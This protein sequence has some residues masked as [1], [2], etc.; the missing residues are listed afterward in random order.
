MIFS[1]FVGKKNSVYFI[2][3]SFRWM[4]LF[5]FSMREKKQTISCYWI[6]K[7]LTPFRCSTLFLGAQLGTRGKIWSDILN[8]Q[9]RKRSYF[10]TFKFPSCV[11]FIHLPRWIWIWGPKIE[12]KSNVIF[13]ISDKKCSI[14]MLYLILKAK[15]FR[16][17]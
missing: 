5:F 11:H 14:S 3:S 6:R 7:I 16:P 4:K 15:S 8:Q 17:F 10:D 13:W 2:S 12:P 1:P 9:S